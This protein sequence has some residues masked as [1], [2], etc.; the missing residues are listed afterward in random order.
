MNF[1]CAFGQIQLLRYKLIR[2][3]ATDQSRDLLLTASERV[4]PHVA[5]LCFPGT[6]H[7]IH[8]QSLGALPRITI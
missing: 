7:G 6:F 8:E 2:M 1:D 5:T 3:S 4:E